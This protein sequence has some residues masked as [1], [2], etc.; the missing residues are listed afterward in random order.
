MKISIRD[1]VEFLFL[2]VLSAGVLVLWDLN[3]S[4][5]TLNVQVGILIEKSSNSD[6]KIK[7]LEERLLRLESK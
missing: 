3:K 5:G 7:S 2:P 6:S 4:V 1:V